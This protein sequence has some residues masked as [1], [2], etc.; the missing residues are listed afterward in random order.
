M[1]TLV[2]DTL[3]C[4]TSILLYLGRIQHLHLLPQLYPTILVPRPVVFELDVGRS[5]Q[6]EIVDPLRLSFAVIKTMAQA[7]IDHLP[8]NR[9]GHGER[10]VIALARQLNAAVAGLDD[11][12]ARLFAISLGLTVKGAVGLIVDAKRSSLIPS[13]TDLLVALRQTGFRLDQ[14]LLATAIELAGEQG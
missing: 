4:D 14:Q 9:L 1:A 11:R 13:A 7:E 8:A 10:S 6:P 5:L 3:V 12:Q 2:C